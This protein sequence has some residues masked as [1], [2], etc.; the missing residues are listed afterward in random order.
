MTKMAQAA[1]HLCAMIVVVF[2]GRLFRK[3]R[4]VNR[5]E[6]CCGAMMGNTRRHPMILNKRVKRRV[7]MERDGERER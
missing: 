2:C 3:S 7:E 1:T 6:G 4:R 5:N